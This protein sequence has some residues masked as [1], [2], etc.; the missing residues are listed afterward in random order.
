VVGSEAMH[1]VRRACTEPAAN[2]HLCGL[3]GLAAIALLFVE[4]SVLPSKA[5]FLAAAAPTVLAALALVLMTARADPWRIDRFIARLAEGA[6]LP[7][8]ATGSVDVCS[9]VLY[10][11]GVLGG[12]AAFAHLALTRS[13]VTREDVVVE[14]G[15]LDKRPLVFAY[16]FV[17]AFVVFH[18]AM[19]VLVRGRRL[20][21]PASAGEPPHRGWVNRVL[22]GLLIAVLAYGWIGAATLRNVSP[23]DGTA[24]AKFYEYHSQVHLGALEQMR[25]GAVPYLEAQ[26]QYGLGNQL[27]LYLLTDVISFSNHGF[28]ASVLL[29]DVVCVVVFFVVVQQ[30]LGLGWALVGLVGWALWPSPAGV[31]DLPGWAV[32]TRWLA[33]PILALWLARLLLGAKLQRGGWVGPAAAGAV[34][35]LGGFMSQENLSGGLLVFFLSLALYGP[36]CGLPLRAVARFA[37]LFVA[38]GV[39]VFVLLV[40]STLGILHVLDVLRQANAQSGLVMAGVSNSVWSD[41]LGLALTLDVMGGWLYGVAKTYGAWK[42]PMETYGFALLLLVSIGLLAGV[43]GRSWR[44]SDDGQGQ[45]IRKFAGVTVGA[46][47]LHLFTLLRADA[48]HLAGP[49]F[50]LPLFLFMLPLFAWRCLRPS[51]GRS[52][53]LAISVG[54]IVEGA[55]AGRTGIG[56]RIEGVGAAWSDS[57]AAFDVYR[58]LFN[59]KDDPGSPA[60]RYSPV[61][62]Y[63]AA[64]RNH[65]SF[66]ELEELTALLHDRLQGRAVELATPG[67]DALITD[68]ELLYF[69]GGFRSVSGI[70]SHKSSIWLRS[71]ED[72]WI[73]K[74]LKARAAC[75]FFDPKSTEGRLFEAWSRLAK[76]PAAVITQPIVGR[77]FYGVLSCKAVR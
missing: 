1:H 37:G 9:V 13:G 70:T 64:F 4:V 29:L 69:F 30:L 44:S 53:L 43:L 56:R 46:Y 35:G 19:A 54:L 21:P 7:V 67:L 45:F 38:S 23:G 15:L 72:A 77:R 59:A 42:A 36:V 74:V 50:L 41:N 31:L 39:A 48:S 14:W 16:V 75:V 47:A 25:Q 12:V 2:L 71:D 65:E 5:T 3:I 33:V 28:Y 10:C 76:D 51:L 17:V 68:P 60:A 27:L 49:S 55:L 66:A 61:P 34:W 73:D 62:A 63:Q 18:R 32:L 6:G 8:R 52:I 22:G 58:A 24:L 26:I 40:G 57:V 20:S 11:A